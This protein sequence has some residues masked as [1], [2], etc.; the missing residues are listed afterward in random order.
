[1]SRLRSPRGQI[2]I[3]VSSP[4]W[5]APT[6]DTHPTALIGLTFHL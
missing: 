2:R 1:L 4:V 3:Y 6:G 5:T